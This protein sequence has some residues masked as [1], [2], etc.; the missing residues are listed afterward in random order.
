MNKPISPSPWSTAACRQG[1]YTIT[2]SD[3][4]MVCKVPCDRLDRMQQA[5]ADTRAIAALPVLIKAL[6]TILLHGEDV[7]RATIDHVQIAL[8]CAKGGVL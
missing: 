4:H 7:G 2:A 8:R 1:F 6:E 5:V 3:G